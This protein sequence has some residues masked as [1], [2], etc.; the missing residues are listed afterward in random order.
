MRFLF[1]LLAGSLLFVPAFG[2]ETS[3]PPTRS[4][5]KAQLLMPSASAWGP[6]GAADVSRWGRTSAAESRTSVADSLP[7]GMPLHTRLFWGDRGLMRTLGLAPA[8]RSGELRLR[9]S[10]LQWH[11][12]MGLLTFGALGT[13][14]VLGEL[15]AANPARYYE[16]LRPVHRTLGYVTFGTYMTTASLS[17][18]APPAR[19][20][21]DG[22]SSVRLHRWLALVHFAGMAVQPWLGIR[23][24]DA[25]SAEAY[26]RRL[27]QHRWVGR[28][29]LAAY[30]TALLSIFLPY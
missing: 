8:T 5:L 15:L 6:P 4:L 13:Q 14:V 22:F 29:T 2:Q 18:F 19:R 27:G 1:A 9:R 7:S 20:Y 16:N 21:S 12:R 24:A 30:T 3:V 11:Q 17:V 26:D 28:I 23:L 25:T 10:M